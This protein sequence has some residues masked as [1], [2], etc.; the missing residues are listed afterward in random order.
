MSERHH[1]KAE[2]PQVANRKVVL[3]MAGMLL[4]MAAVAF[5]FTLLFANRIGVRFVPHLAFHAFPAPAVIPDERAQRVSLEAQQRR[6]L[7]GGNGR[8]PIGQAMQAMAARGAQAFD[9][10]P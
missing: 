9:P 10:V 3:A 4:L 1:G 6:L 2:S 5:G 8:M 7:A